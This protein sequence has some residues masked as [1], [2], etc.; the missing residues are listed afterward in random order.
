MRRNG[1]I[2][3]VAVDPED[4]ERVEAAGPW[5]VYPMRSTFYCKRHVPRTGGGRTTQHL[6]AFLGFKGGDHLDGNG[7]NNCKA[8]LR[9]VTQAENRQNLR[10]RKDNVSGHRGVSF[11]K[12]TGKWR[13][14]VG[15]N[16]KNVYLGRYIN[17]EDA[18]RAASEYRAKH[19]P[20]SADAMR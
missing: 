9:H 17:I 5:N 8:N 2:L 20:F 19:M 1:D 16:G 14:D 7:L 10:L 13:A 6:H 3:T 15:L 11:E 12:A 18:V 4:F